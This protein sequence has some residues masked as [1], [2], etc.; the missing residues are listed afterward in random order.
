MALFV[1]RN[2]TR[3]TLHELNLFVTTNNTVI[4]SAVNSIR[5]LTN[6]KFFEGIDMF[7]VSV[8]NNVHYYL[9]VIILAKNEGYVIDGFNRDSCYKE[10]RE[11]TYNVLWLVSSYARIWITK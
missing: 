7:L 3:Y 1:Q 6:D 11:N 4:K 10:A 9:C 8:L 5:G 2:L